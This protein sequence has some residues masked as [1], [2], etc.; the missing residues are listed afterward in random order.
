[1]VN[2]IGKTVGGALIAGATVA[3]WFWPKPEAVAQEDV[4]VRPIRSEIVEAGFKS[5]DL[6]FPARIKAGA[7]RS[8]SFK[9]A[10]RIASIP[11]NA[12]DQVKKGAVLA[13]LEKESFVDAVEIAKARLERDQLAY[14][15]RLSAAEKNAISK[16]ELSSAEAEFRQS[17]SQL[18]DAERALEEATL[19]AP[20][21]GEVSRKTVT[22]LRN[23][24]AGEE[25]LV[26]HDVSTIEV[27]VVVPE[28]M[29]IKIN[30]LKIHELK[31]ETL[32]ISFDSAPGVS[33]PVTFKDFETTANEGTQTFLATYTLPAPK[34]L[35]LLPG[36]SGTLKLNGK[37][38]TFDS[39]SLEKEVTVPETA[40]GI[41]AD[42]SAF[43]WVLTPAQEPGV[44]TVASR[45]V[46][47]GYRTAGRVMIE[48]GLKSGERVA[49]AG[50]AVLTEGRKVRL[51]G[52]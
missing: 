6:F 8:M 34:D 2:V 36:M 17:R 24:A 47:I 52:E 29:V 32:S 41:A 18:R 42:G 43:V 37:D 20:F 38:Y 48:D 16:E 15:R 27:Q 30:S 10:G 33:Y 26:F 31:P 45:T 4:S 46:K 51:L 21:D 7:S 3:V 40:V 1:M 44:Y 28:T 13:T 49:T 23:I 50:V 11:V 12:G 35:I 22:E 25:V 9:H 14:E 5:P 19:V 39:G